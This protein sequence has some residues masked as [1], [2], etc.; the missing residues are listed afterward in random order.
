MLINKKRK[1]VNLKT[2]NEKEKATII[3]KLHETKRCT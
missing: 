3:S 1:E 2:R